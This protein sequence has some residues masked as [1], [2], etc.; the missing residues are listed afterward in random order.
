V[1]SQTN[2]TRQFMDH[3]LALFWYVE[4]P[5]F[6]FSEYI[7]IPLRLTVCIENVY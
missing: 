1:Q 7:P 3:A 6:N 5:N 4:T 2:A